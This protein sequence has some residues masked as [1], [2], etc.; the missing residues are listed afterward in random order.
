M[1]IGVTIP[2]HWGVENVHDVL[3]M[4]PFAESLGFD[5][6][7]TMD[8]LLNI[9]RVRARLGNRPYWHPMA[10]LSHIGATTERILLGTSVLV[11]PYHDPVGLAKYAATLDHM[12]RGRLLLGVGVGAL[13]EEFA[14][15]GVPMGKRG[16]LTDE[17]IAVMK[18]LWTNPHP[19]F[20]G[21]RFRFADLEFSP[22]CYRAPHVPLLIGGASDAA[23]RRVA[24]SGDG[25]H[26]SSITA[27][28]YGAGVER[29]RQ[30]A[31]DAGRNAEAIDMSLRFDVDVEALPNRTRV[32][33][34]IS[35]LDAY[36]Q[37]GCEHALIA[38]TSNDIPRLRHWMQALSDDV[39]SVLR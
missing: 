3:A 18:D 21:G 4:G 6:V 20:Q 26:P 14:A 31:G 5:S 24:R 13:S 30:L 39:I 25:W 1:K 19:N 12:S 28:D 15:L 2:N 10:I 32:H 38:L 22:R 9:A 34:L 7:W 37:V 27:H 35:D 11:L 33:Q 29:I 8:H 23:I 16:A 36:R 17:S